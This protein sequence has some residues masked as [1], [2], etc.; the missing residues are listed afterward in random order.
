LAR[1][2]FAPTRFH[3]AIG[4]PCAVADGDTIV[5]STLDA[6]GYDGGGAQ[7][8]EGPAIASDSEAIVRP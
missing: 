3:N 1:H 8:P 6:R 5:A 4:N 7:N 2:V